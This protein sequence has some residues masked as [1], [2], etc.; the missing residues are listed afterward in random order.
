MCNTPSQHRQGAHLCLRSLSPQVDIYNHKVCDTRPVWQETKYPTA[1]YHC[2]SA[3]TV[4]VLTMQSR[5]MKW[6]N[7]NLLIKKS[8]TMTITDHWFSDN[9]SVLSASEV[10]TTVR[11]INWRFT[12]LLTY[13]TPP[14][15][16]PTK[17]LASTV[18]NVFLCR[19]WSVLRWTWK[20]GQ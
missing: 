3:C 8:N 10:L 7:W 14:F 9:I 20:I 12:Y 19:T 16:I 5:Y 13:I 15:H 6:N 1:G 2:P 18:L 11:Y 17:Y 4:S